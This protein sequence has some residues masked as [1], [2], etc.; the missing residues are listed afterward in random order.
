M[1]EEV[2]IFELFGTAHIWTIIVAFIIGFLIVFLTTKYASNKQQK[3][4]ATAIGI[5]MIIEDIYE[6][7]YYILIAG[8]ALKDNLPLHLCG[9]TT[10][11]TAIMLITRSKW[12]FQYVYFWGLGGATITYLTPDTHWIFPDLLYITFFTS[13][14]LI[15]VGV[16]LMI[17]AFNNRPTVKSL[18][19]SFWGLHVLA[20]FIGLI[21]YILDTNYMFLCEK[22]NAETP[23]DF[24]GPWPWYIISLE[25][26][27]IITWLILYAPYYFKDKRNKTT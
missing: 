1:A 20:I 11:L 5:F 17:F 10:L 14:G 25:I 27:V 18:W 8:E 22:P 13:H 15:I 19:R 23:M 16:F 3:I 26:A 9:L 4:I 7:G 24:M 2:H 12:L 6:H 21:N